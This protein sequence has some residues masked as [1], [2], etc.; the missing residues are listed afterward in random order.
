MSGGFRLRLGARR[1]ASVSLLY[2]LLSASAP[3]SASRPQ[4]EAD[5]HDFS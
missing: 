3:L 4:T 5:L 1:Y 2:A